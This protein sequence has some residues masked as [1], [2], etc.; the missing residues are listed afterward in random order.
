MDKGKIPLTRLHVPA[1]SG[2]FTEAA[3]HAQGK[4]DHV[5]DIR[6]DTTTGWFPNAGRV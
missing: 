5:Q 2:L 3:G 6:D 1:A 4:I